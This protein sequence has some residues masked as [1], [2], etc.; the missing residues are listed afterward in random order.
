M[1][2]DPSCNTSIVSNGRSEGQ[3]KEPWTHFWDGCTPETEIKRIDNLYLRPWIV[4]YVPRFGKS[5][6][7]G[8]GLGAYV[9][10]LRRLGIDIEGLEFS[11]DI[12][13]AVNAWQASAGLD[14]P[15]RVGD[16]T[17]LPYD[18]NSLSGYISLGVVEHFEQGPMA[19]LS[20]A[21]RVLRPGG[22]GIITTPA[23]GY[24]RRM[25]AGREG[26]RRIRHG[27]RCA[28]ERDLGRIRQTLWVGLTLALDLFR[29]RTKTYIGSSHFQ[30]LGRFWQYEHRPSVLSRFLKKSGFRV[31]WA[32]STDLRFNEYILG[33]WRGNVQADM[34]RIRR[35]D[36]LEACPLV[37]WGRC[38]AVTIAVKPGAKEHCFLCGEPN[39]H[40]PVRAIPICSA[41]ES[42][43]LASHYKQARRPDLAGR[44]IYNPSV[45]EDR[46][47]QTCLH[48]GE[49]YNLDPLFENAGFL[50]PTCDVCLKR[51]EVN[52]RLSN[53][54]LRL[55]WRPREN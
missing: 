27:L 30:D 43:P 52:I 35:L 38:F 12:V 37:N 25:V 55:V 17:Q 40:G 51:P 3:D 39:V 15:I 26:L 49:R 45:P 47:A 10:Y 21:R 20:E 5:V 23:P 48:C 29:S 18:D 36:R 31:I 41:C 24:A 11:A 13:G 33:R 34:R 9:F 16:V 54:R 28:R 8:C 1:T 2:T 4:K 14:A 53:E 22:I 6:E 46:T 50:D 7:A 32:G 42:S 19:V 44:W